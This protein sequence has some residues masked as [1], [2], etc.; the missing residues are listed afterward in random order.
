MHRPME[1]YGRIPLEQDTPTDE[2][3]FEKLNY[4]IIN[5]NY[6][7]AIEFMNSFIND[8]P[9]KWEAID[10]IVR[11]GVNNGHFPKPISIKWLGHKTD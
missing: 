4:F 11:H 8:D 7:S 6:E 9:E 10:R 2:Q 5:G 3:R 1:I